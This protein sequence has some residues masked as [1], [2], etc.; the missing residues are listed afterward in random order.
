MILGSCDGLVCINEPCPEISICIWNPATREYKQVP[1]PDWESYTTA[2]GFGFDCK[3]D[4]YKL[5]GIESYGEGEDSEAS[6]YSLASNSWKELGIIPYDFSSVMLNK[7]LLVNGVLRWITTD[8]RTALKSSIVVCYDISD[9]TFHHVPLPNKNPREIGDR[10]L[11]VWEGKLCLLSSMNHMEDPDICA[12]QN[13]HIDVW[14]MM[15]NKWSKQLKITA[16]MT[17]MYYL[18][19]I[20]TLQNGEI[21]FTGGAKGEP[22]VGLISYDPNLDRVRALKIHGFPEWSDEHTYIETL[23]ALN[24]GTYVGQ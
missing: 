5:L 19:P 1:E 14:T 20:Q 12:H 6:L 3:N 9:E 15:D 13:D 23:V 8:P 11:G 7:G 21:L 24:S 4:D 17:D 16:H 22:G 2:H 10:H 18:S